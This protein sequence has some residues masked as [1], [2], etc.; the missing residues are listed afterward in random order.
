[1]VWPVGT[2]S[3]EINSERLY[4]NRHSKSRLEN[5]GT[6]YLAKCDAE[7]CN[8]DIWKLLNLE[9]YFNTIVVPIFVV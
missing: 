2:T 5:V 6:I 4:N 7:N 8:Q 9:I 1:M 3:T